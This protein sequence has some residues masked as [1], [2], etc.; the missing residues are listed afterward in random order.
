MHATND[1]NIDKQDKT[2]TTEDEAID[3]A[4]LQMELL[5][6]SRCIQPPR[7]T[8]ITIREIEKDE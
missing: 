5:Y 1:N 2:S 7:G 3:T 8:N 4:L 6:K